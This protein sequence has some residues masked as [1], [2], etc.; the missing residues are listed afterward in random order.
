MWNDP[1]ATSFASSSNMIQLVN[2]NK[3]LS[4]D[5]QVSQAE[6]LWVFKS[7]QNAFN[8]GTSDN[9]DELFRTMFPDSKIAQKF[10]IRHSKMSV[11]ISHGLGPYFLE[12]LIKNCKNCQRFVLCFDEQTNNQSKKQLDLYFRY[13]SSQKG[14]VATRYYR[15][16]LLGHAQATVVVHGILDSFR[17]DSIDISKMLML[18]RDNPNVNKT[19]EK[20]IN[21][22]MK[23]VNV[24]L[25]NIGTCNLHVIYNGFKADTGNLAKIKTMTDYVLLHKNS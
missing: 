15:T 20:I 17:T 7:V 24:D 13:W 18:S 5:D 8:Y 25:L 3:S 11:I 10:S 21:D 19:V 14:L 12:Q 16:V 22:A 6:I 1:T 4:F 2:L 23:K 9:V